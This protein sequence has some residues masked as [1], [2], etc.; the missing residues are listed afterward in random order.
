MH[1]GLVYRRRRSTIGRGNVAANF[2]HAQPNG[3][4]YRTAVDV[5]LRQHDNG[6]FYRWSGANLVS[7]SAI[8]HTFAYIL[9]TYTS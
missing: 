5:H 4:R 3:G 7:L 9:Q 6:I 2:P 8:Y 1:P